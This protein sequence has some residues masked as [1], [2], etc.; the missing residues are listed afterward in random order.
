MCQIA[1][2][3]EVLR[4]QTSYVPRSKRCHLSSEVT[5]FTLNKRENTFAVHARSKT[6]VFATVDPKFVVRPDE[7]N[8]VIGL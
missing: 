3:N 1:L 5:G 8:I 6:V 2:Q 7:T 4:L